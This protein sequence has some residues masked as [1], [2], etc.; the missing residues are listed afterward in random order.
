MTGQSQ[1]S[2]LVNRVSGLSISFD[3]LKKIPPTFGLMCLM[4]NPVDNSGEERGGWAAQLHITS[5]SSVPRTIL[6]YQHYSAQCQ[7]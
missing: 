2:L 1:D 7:P 4:E 6:M 3:W 5:C